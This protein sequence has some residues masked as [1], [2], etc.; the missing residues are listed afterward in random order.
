MKKRKIPVILQWI[1]GVLFIISGLGGLS[2]YVPFAVAALLFGVSL[3]PA[4]WKPLRKYSRSGKK[5]VRYAVS[6]VLFL[7]C[8]ATASGMSKADKPDTGEPEAAMV[9]PASALAETDEEEPELSVTVSSLLPEEEDKEDAE[10]GLSSVLPVSEVSVTEA[11][12]YDMTIHFLDVGQG[13]SVFVQSGEETLI[14]DGGDS[15]HSSFVVAYLKK[16]GVTSIDYLISSHYD[17]DHVSGLIGCLKAFDV[18]QVISSDYEHDS[19]TYTSFVN[20]V[21]DKGLT[22]L[23]P[24]VGEEFAFGTGKFIILAPA[25]IDEDGSNDNSVAIKLINGENSFLFTGDA[26]SSSEEAMCA[27]GIDLQCDVLVPGHHGSATATSWDL[28]QAALPEFAVISCGADN[29]YGHPHKDTLDKLQAADIQVYRTDVQ[30]TVIVASDGE[31]LNWD[32]EPCND[33]SPGDGNDS[34][35]QAG[36]DT[37][38]KAEA[39]K[40]GDP[41]ESSD[42]GKESGEAKASETASEEDADEPAVSAQ[43]QNQEEMVWLPATG[44]K[45]HKIPDCGRMNPDKATQV[46]RSEAERRGYEACKK[47]Y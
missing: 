44:E 30:G 37:V 11:P 34:G 22:M 1:F 18:K 23:H 3:L 4:V 25:A 42:T 39:A 26:E 33:Y 41:A 47:C 7:L 35:T 31:A 12:G 14:Y 15:E 32:Q 28:L 21:A 24:A 13:L 2:E 9:S 16:Q 6:V 17:S 8:M 46:T 38:S 19:K 5:W 40:A 20:A 45:Y 43:S 27:S 29:P 36:E 10:S